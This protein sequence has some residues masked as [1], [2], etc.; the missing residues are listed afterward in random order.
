MGLA[1]ANARAQLGSPSWVYRASQSDRR[2][3]GRLGI[4]AEWPKLRCSLGAVEQP[5]EVTLWGVSVAR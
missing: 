1:N 5:V 2:A 3:R 4:V